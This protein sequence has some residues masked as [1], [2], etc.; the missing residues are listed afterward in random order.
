MNVIVGVFMEDS[1]NTVRSRLERNGALITQSDVSTITYKSFNEAGSAVV[2]QTSLTVSDVVYDAAQ[3]NTTDPA[4]RNASE[5]Y[6]FKVDV[7]AAAFATGGEK[8]TVEIKITL[9]DG[10]V[11]HLIAR[12]EVVALYGS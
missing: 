10:V 4:W 6:N 12:G 2:T 11:G 8:A 1:T 7:P 9:D 5:G 3:T